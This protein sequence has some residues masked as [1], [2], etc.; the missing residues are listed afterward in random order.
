MNAVCLSL[1]EDLL[2]ACAVGTFFTARVETMGQRR[3]WRI[4]ISVLM[5]TG[6]LAQSSP[7]PLPPGSA[8]SE[9]KVIDIVVSDPQG[10]IVPSAGIRLM[11]DRGYLLASGVTNRE[12]SLEL[13]GPWPE[14]AILEVSMP[15]F[16]PFRREVK[17]SPDQATSVHVTLEVGTASCSP[18]IE[19]TARL[20][21]PILLAETKI[22]L[23]PYTPLGGVSSPQKKSLPEIKIAPIPS[24][25]LRNVLKLAR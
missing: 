12:G 24:A 2:Q 5:S 19:S 22:D 17:S 23:I 7:T 16:G 6:L 21:D 1:R 18:C 4:A 20:I 25:P 15:G 13:T 9:Q 14:S 11:N 3:V 8:K 10:A